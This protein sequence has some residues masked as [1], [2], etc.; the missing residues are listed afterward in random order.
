MTLNREMQKYFKTCRVR[1]RTALAG[2]DDSNVLTVTT[3]HLPKNLDMSNDVCHRHCTR[4][5]LSTCSSVSGTRHRGRRSGD[6]VGR[7]PETVSFFAVCLFS[8][9]LYEDSVSI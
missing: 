5:I 3:S 8:G 2:M 4:M 1:P 7:T 6:S 9:W